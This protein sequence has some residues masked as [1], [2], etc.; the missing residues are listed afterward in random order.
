MCAKAMIAVSVVLGL[1]AAS[2]PPATAAKA[3]VR[4]RAP[5]VAEQ[6]A[7]SAPRGPAVLPFTAD[8]QRLFDRAS[9]VYG[10]GR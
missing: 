2:I 8:E 5:G 9:T 3:K 10:A 1:G 7:A 6:P 4:H